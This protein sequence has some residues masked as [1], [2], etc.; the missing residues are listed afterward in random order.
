[1]QLVLDC[2]VA[3]SWCFEDEAT[4]GADAVL[5]RLRTEE[6]IVP[7]LWH[8][9]VAN[10]L[11]L[12]ERK[13]RITKAQVTEFIALL[14]DL[15]IVTDHEA[16]RRALSTI[17]DLARSNHLTSYDATYLELAR[18]R[19]LPLVSRDRDLRAAAKRAGVAL[20]DG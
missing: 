16:A 6:A 12:S 9:E 15:P 11:A 17:L 3:L 18:R 14:G 2:S 13:R 8:L 20:I 1:V 19:G 4:P 5:E 10:V 7:S